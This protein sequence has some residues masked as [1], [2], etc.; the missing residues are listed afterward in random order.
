M[1]ELGGA[2]VVK[3][4]PWARNLNRSGW[5]IVCE[6]GID[7]LALAHSSGTMQCLE[8]SERDY[9][10][11]WTGRRQDGT[12]ILLAFIAYAQAIRIVCHLLGP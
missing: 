3:D 5:M 12:G 1:G 11:R 4:R 8:R 2:R 9:L 10:P 6:Y 7:A